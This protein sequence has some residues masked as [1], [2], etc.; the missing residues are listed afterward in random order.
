MALV[1]SNLTKSQK[2]WKKAHRNP[3]D[4][5]VLKAFVEKYPH[6]LFSDMTQETHIIFISQDNGERANQFSPNNNINNSIRIGQIT[7]E[8][9]EKL[10]YQQPP[11]QPFPHYYHPGEMI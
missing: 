10:I 7:H 6:L 11:N 4:L 9:N 1:K 5:G 3:F 2:Y 8:E